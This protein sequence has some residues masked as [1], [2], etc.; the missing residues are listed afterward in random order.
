ML[1]ENIPEINHWLLEEYRIKVNFGTFQFP[2][3][4]A[5]IRGNFQDQMKLDINCKFV[6]NKATV[7]TETHPCKQR[8]YQLN[9]AVTLTMQGKHCLHRCN[10]LQISG[11]KPSIIGYFIPI[12]CLADFTE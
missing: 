11:S 8:T 2:D 10:R 9:P 5:P 1:P 3:L 6:A 12:S 7:T 4:P